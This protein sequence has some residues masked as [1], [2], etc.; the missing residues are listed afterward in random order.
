V[1]N[2]TQER[3]SSLVTRLRDSGGKLIESSPAAANTMLE[4]ADAVE[5]LIRVGDLDAAARSAFDLWKDLLEYP[6]IRVALTRAPK[7]ATLPNDAELEKTRETVI[8]FND[9]VREI[10]SLLA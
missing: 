3:L 10:G 9:L 1:P 4:G 6:E 7:G 5:Q 8:Y 2:V